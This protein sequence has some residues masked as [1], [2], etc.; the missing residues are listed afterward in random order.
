L[1]LGKC[2]SRSAQEEVCV[3]NPFGMAIEDLSLAHRVYQVARMRS[4]GVHLPR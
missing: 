4:M 1:L 2:E 3:V